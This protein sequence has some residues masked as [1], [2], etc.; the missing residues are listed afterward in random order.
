MKPRIGIIPREPGGIGHELIAKLLNDAETCE[1]AKIL[2][3]GD[4]HLFEMG[5]KI[6]ASMNYNSSRIYFNYEV[7][8]GFQIFVNS[9]AA[10]WQNLS[11]IH[12]RER[13]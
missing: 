7:N 8:I 5:C 6:L 11:H 3:I 1:K 2:L 12:A 10:K 9:I 4:Q 13:V